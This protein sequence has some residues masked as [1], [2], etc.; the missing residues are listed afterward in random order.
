MRL[1]TWGRKRRKKVT[2]VSEASQEAPGNP[3]MGRI[4][5][6]IFTVGARRS[7]NHLTAMVSE[8]IRRSP[9][10][11]YFSVFLAFWM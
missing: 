9:I 5:C 8:N 7:Q 11:Y 6:I 10:K 4:S 2:H 3:G 1:F